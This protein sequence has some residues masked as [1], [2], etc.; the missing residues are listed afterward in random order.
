VPFFNEPVFGADRDVFFTTDGKWALAFY[1]RRPDAAALARLREIA[2]PRR[3]GILSGGGGAYW[4][5]RF[6]WPASLVEYGGRAGFASPAYDPRY[7]FPREGA[8]GGFVKEGYWFSSARNIR[9]LTP[10]ARGT[11]LGTLRSCLDLA[12]AV[13][14]LHRDGLLIPGL[15][16]R[17]CLVDPVSGSACLVGLDRLFVP[18]HAPPAVPPAPDFLPPEA[19]RAAPAAGPGLPYGTPGG[20]TPSA[21][22]DRHALAVLLYLLLFRRRPPEGGRDAVPLTPPPGVRAGDPPAG[23]E[24]SAGGR[25]GPGSPSPGAA[26]A[27]GASPG[28]AGDRHGPRPGPGRIPAAVL[29]PR[30]AGLFERAFAAGQGDPSRRPAA[31]EWEDALASTVDLLLRCKSPSCPAGWHYFDG[32][33]STGCPYCGTPSGLPSVPLL[34]LVPVHGCGAGG[35]GAPTGPAGPGSPAGQAGAGGAATQ[36]R[37]LTVFDGQYLYQWHAFQG[38]S[39]GGPHLAPEMRKP[40]GY[41][42]FH[43]GE[44]LLVNQSLPD[45]QDLGTGSTT[46]PGQAVRLRDGQTLRLSRGHGGLAAVVRIWKADAGPA[47]SAGAAGIPAGAAPG[48]AGPAGGAACGGAAQDSSAGVGAVPAG[49]EPRGPSP[50]GPAPP[51]AGPAPAP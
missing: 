19:R 16:S 49:P 47:A 26:G 41:F 12:R 51:G 42:S 50:G 9:R 39:P 22:S 23:G 29:G 5:E 36:G 3:A 24:A 44:W 32:S 13:D 31:S 18:G 48:G 4:A 25:A 1:R 17:S 28:P 34:N 20:F 10:S 37:S 38:V 40:V 14:R 8:F 21:G 6:R 27:A 7:F 45:L 2:G 43:N 15:S 35:A 46:P 33:G 30:L 11:L